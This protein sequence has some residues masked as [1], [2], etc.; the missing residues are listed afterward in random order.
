[1]PRRTSRRSRSASFKKGV[2]KRTRSGLDRSR[3]LTEGCLERWVLQFVV[4]A[5]ARVL[6]LL[7]LR[8]SFFRQA[9]RKDVARRPVHDDILGRLDE[10]G[11]PMSFPAADDD[12]IHFAVGGGANDLALGVADD[13]SPEAWI[14]RLLQSRRCCICGATELVITHCQQRCTS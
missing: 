13:D 2:C 3:V 4:P 5:V 9:N 1:M 6:L 8:V 10:K 7:R 12:E 14:N 11:E